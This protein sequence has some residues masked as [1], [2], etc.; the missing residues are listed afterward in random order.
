M[1]ER[2]EDLLQFWATLNLFCTP[3]LLILLVDHIRTDPSPLLE[4]LFLQL[5]SALFFMFAPLVLVNIFY[6]RDC[7]ERR[8]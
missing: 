6:E 2:I 4:L 1:N 8:F 3:I 5:P 7:R